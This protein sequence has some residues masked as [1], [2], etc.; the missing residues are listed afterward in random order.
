MDDRYAV[1]DCP[2]AVDFAA[3]GDFA[4]PAVDLAVVVA[5]PDPAKAILLQPTL[6]RARAARRA[7]H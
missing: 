1:V 2:G 4:L 3:E 7:A 5:D 6:Q